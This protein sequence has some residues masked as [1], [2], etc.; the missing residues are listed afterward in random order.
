LTEQ[1]RENRILQR[2]LDLL[3][4]QGNDPTNVHK[5]NK[6]TRDEILENRNKELRES[7]EN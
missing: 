3:E 1:K 4:E 5:L 6:Q 7:N 2:K